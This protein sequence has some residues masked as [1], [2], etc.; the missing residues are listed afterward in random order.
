MNVTTDLIRAIKP[1]QTRAFACETA[2]DMY[3][4]CSLVA[5]LKRI[6]LPDGVKNY[7]TRKD[8]GENVVIIRALGEND[9]PMLNR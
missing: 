6:G 9:E 7:E 2:S 4:A 1:G 8:F 5:R 3:S